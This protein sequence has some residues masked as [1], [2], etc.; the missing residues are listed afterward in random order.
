MIY[1]IWCGEN[2]PKQIE[3]S[4]VIVYPD[5][6]NPIEVSDLERFHL[7]SLIPTMIYADFDVIPQKGFFDYF[8]NIKAG[9]PHFAYWSDTPDY[10]L[11]AVNG[12]IL[13]FKG[14][15][16]SLLRKTYNYGWVRKILR[17]KD[18][19]RIPENIYIHLRSTYSKHFNLSNNFTNT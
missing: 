8:N 16:E 13:F 1:Q 17:Y 11:F 7:A 15:Y 6:C 3:G 2:H 18:V 14:I 9:K 5:C 4:K 19:E 10:F 12:D